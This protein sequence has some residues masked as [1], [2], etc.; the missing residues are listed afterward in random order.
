MKSGY[1]QLKITELDEKLK[2]IN[3]KA[4]KTT[5][6]MNKIEDKIGQYDILLEKLE[7]LKAI[8]YTPAKWIKLIE[9]AQNYVLN[10][11]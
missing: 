11:T 2:Q 10:S 4:N 6:V 3:Q 5:I 7:E 9:L 1:L 8:T